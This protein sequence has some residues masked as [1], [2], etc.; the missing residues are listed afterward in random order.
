MTNISSTVY[1]VYQGQ[2]G[3]FTITE[4]DRQG[5]IIYR[6]ALLTAAICFAIGSLLAILF[7]PNPLI[8]NLLTGFYFAFSIALGI[9]LANIHIYLKLLHRTLQVF[10]GI[11]SG[12]ALIFT[13]IAFQHQQSLA[14]YIYEHPLTILGV[15][16]TFAAIAGIYFKEAFCFNRFETKFLVAIAPSL[17]LG[18]LLGWLSVDIEKSLLIA[19]AVLFVIFGLRKFFQAIPDDIGDKSVFEYLEKQAKS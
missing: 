14:T 4:S 9:A 19:W 15:G 7:A 6:S 13:A 8:L 1:P 12:A 3:E 5:V 18:H 16:F 10:L 2:F 11:G 17:L